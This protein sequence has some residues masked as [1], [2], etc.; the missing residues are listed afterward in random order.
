MKNMIGIRG[1]RGIFD[2]EKVDDGSIYVATL[3][4]WPKIT[5]VACHRINRYNGMRTE[6]GKG[7]RTLIFCREPCTETFI[8]T[9]VIISRYEAEYNKGEDIF[10]KQ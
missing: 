3:L 4:Y 9:M 6:K 2:V 8:K 1:K 10:N 7:S 5:L